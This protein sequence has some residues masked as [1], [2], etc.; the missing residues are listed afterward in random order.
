MNRWYENEFEKAVANTEEWGLDVPECAKTDVEFDLDHIRDNIHNFF[1]IRR[2]RFPQDMAGEC[3]DRH[4]NVKGW[5]AHAIGLQT[6]LTIGEVLVNG[7]PRYKASYELFRQELDEPATGARTFDAHVWLTLPNHG[8]LDV[9]LPAS[10]Y[11]ERMKEKGKRK[12][13]YEDYVLHV[14]PES[15]GRRVRST[16]RAP[17]NSKDG[18]FIYT[19]V[20]R[21]KQK[22]V[23]QP[24]LVGFDFLMKS[25]ESLQQTFGGL[26]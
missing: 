8:V 15:R 5:L 7:S 3:I 2:W 6:Y 17:V 16:V 24:M 13:K 18:S 22:V 20:Y 23:Y 12:P 11:G 10:L 14:G 26:E 21:K 25:D 1:N 19:D 4:M 9:V